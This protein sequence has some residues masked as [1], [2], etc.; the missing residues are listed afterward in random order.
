MA[1]D[2]DSNRYPQTVRIPGIALV[3]CSS[4]V[5]WDPETEALDYKEALGQV[6]VVF[7]IVS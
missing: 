7:E 3:K 1:K 2:G 5:Y 4:E 6:E